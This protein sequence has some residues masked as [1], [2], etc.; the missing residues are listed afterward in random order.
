[1][2]FFLFLFRKCKFLWQKRTKHRIYPNPILQLRGRWASSIEDSGGPHTP[3]NP[4]I[5][6]L[7]LGRGEPVYLMLWVGFLLTL[8][9]DSL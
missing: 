4:Q 1:M 6:Q 2:L 7:L 9:E 3:Q 8:S 5:C